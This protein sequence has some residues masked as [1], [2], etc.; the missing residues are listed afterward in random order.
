MHKI[1]KKT[2]LVLDAPKACCT[3]SQLAACAL[4]TT[5]KFSSKL[6]TL[7]ATLGARRIGTLVKPF[8]RRLRYT[9]SAL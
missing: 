8:V 3:T 5:L 9:N 2:F 6:S 7:G 4:Y 1:V